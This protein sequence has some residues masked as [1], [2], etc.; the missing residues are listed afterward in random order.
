MRFISLLIF[1]INLKGGYDKMTDNVCIEKYETYLTEVKKSS[2]NTLS[3][4]LRDI[5]QLSDYLISHTDCGID[6]ADEDVLTEYITW[7]TMWIGNALPLLVLL[8]KIGILLGST[9][10]F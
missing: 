3:S 9:V 1:L 4:Y 6:T 2:V 10:V 5:R 7:H 8:P